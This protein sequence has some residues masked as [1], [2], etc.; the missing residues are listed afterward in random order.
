[1]HV[2]VFN[3]KLI[4]EVGQELLLELP[5]A[6]PLLHVVDELPDALSLKLQKLAH[7]RVLS[8]VKTTFFL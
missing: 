4:P 2:V 8:M 3:D 7:F 1:V 6:Q 5:V